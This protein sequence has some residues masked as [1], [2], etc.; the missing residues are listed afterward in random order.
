MS[1]SPPVR[2]AASGLVRVRVRIGSGI[3]SA[4]V[5]LEKLTGGSQRLTAGSQPLWHR[6]GVRVPAARCRVR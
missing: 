6:R 4:H 2:A 5:E 1:R 3:R